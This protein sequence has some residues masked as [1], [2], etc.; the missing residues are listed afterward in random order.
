MA[1]MQIAREVED[2]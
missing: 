2:P 1:F